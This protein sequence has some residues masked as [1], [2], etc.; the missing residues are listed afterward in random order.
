MNP[1]GRT[2]EDLTGRKFGRWTVLYRAPNVMEPRGR[3]AIVWHCRCECG[4]E[5]DVKAGSLKSGQSKSCGCL[6]SDVLRVNRNLVGQR[7]GRWVVL[8]PGKDYVSPK[9]RHLRQWHCKC[10]CG[11]ERDV[12]ENALVGGKSV[13]CGCYRKEQCA[14][15]A[16]YKDLTGKRFGKW[17]VKGRAPD[18]FYPGG[19]R[20]QMW[21]CQCD[22]GNTN[23]VA[24]NMLKSG[25]SQSCG[26]FYNEMPRSEYWVKWYLDEGGIRYR[27]QVKASDLRSERDRLL[28]YDFLIVD[29][30]NGP[31]CFIECQGEQHYNP[32][33]FF[34]G[35]DQFERQ[36]SNDSIKRLYAEEHGIPLIE[37]PYTIRTHQQISDF[38]DFHLSKILATD[39]E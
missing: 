37:L 38:L 17:V 9:G 24:G 10:D 11:T 4:T 36:M 30:D 6:K 2:C 3:E 19:G 12:T 32:V 22:C 29:K 15:A 21:Y 25:I 1:K 18:R 34:G 31:L 23:I 27:R 7:F 13:S 26:C 8:G 35:K 39:E 28:S 5:R 33:T 20:A 14:E 16:T